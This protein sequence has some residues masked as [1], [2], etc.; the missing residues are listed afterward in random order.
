MRRRSRRTEIP[1]KVSEF[2]IRLRV[3]YVFQ[4]IGPTTAKLLSPSR[5][6]GLGTVNT[7]HWH[8]PWASGVRNQSTVA[9]SSYIILYGL[10]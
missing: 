7:L 10:L 2:N 8:E 1:F 3:K 5:V 9:P 6:F 4:I